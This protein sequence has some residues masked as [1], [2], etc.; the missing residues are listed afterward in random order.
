MATT[1]ARETEFTY[2][3]SLFTNTYLNSAYSSMI[4][5]NMRY[6]LYG[7]AKYDPH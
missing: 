7:A 2:E 4:S 1:D 3:K 5:H 6:N